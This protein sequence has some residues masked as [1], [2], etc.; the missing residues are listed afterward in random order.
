M[1]STRPAPGCSPS[2][3]SSRRAASCCA[4]TSSCSSSHIDEQRERLRLTIRDLSALVEDPA[5]LR[6]A[7][8]PSAGRGHDPASPSPSRSP[9]ASRTGWWPAAA[10]RTTTS[11]SGPP[12]T[13]RPR[14]TS[15]WPRRPLGAAT[16][17]ERAAGRP[18]AR[19]WPTPRRRRGRPG[20]RGRGRLPGRAPQGH[21]RRSARSG[22]G[23][24][25]TTA[26][27]AGPPTGSPG[28]AA[29]ADPRRTI[30]RPVAA[31]A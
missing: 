17:P 22:L 15:P 6:E 21:D 5:A 29:A 11:P 9:S 4:A 2:S 30:R 1:P 14:T 12:P 8:V 24:T 18:S 26:Y 28:S 19:S 20:R 3:R 27:G 25:R 31:T 7:L 16:A 13:R 23:T 10:P